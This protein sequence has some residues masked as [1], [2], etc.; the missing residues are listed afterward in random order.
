MHFGTISHW[1]RQLCTGALSPA[2]LV[3]ELADTIKQHNPA[4][5]AYISWDTEAAL[6]EAAQADL[7]KPLGGIP[8]AIKDNICLQ[9]QP[10]RCASRILENFISPYDA[11]AISR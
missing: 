9:N 3:Q 11:T 7:S 5:N 8:L 10:T 2:E 6:A 4:L 1:R